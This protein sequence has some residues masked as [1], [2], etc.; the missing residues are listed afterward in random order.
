[1]ARDSSTTTPIL[2]LQNQ[3]GSV[4]IGQSAGAN[5]VDLRVYGD[6]LKVGGG[7]WDPVSDKR[8]KKNIKP[9]SEGLKAILKINPVKYQ[10]NGK[11]GL[12][13][14]KEYIG[15]IA[16]DLG[17]VCPNLVKHFSSKIKDTDT[18]ETEFLSYNA[19]GITYMMLNA[20]KELAGQVET[21]QSE[22]SDLKKKK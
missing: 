20:I 14:D 5:P 21:L 10:Y 22:L 1:M 15:L 11:A 16:Q 12:P 17:K 4:R 7:A 2:R 9:F 3:G 19:D 18:E 13:T 6:A 8:L